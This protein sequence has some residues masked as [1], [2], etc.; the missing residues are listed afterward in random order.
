MSLMM[1]MMIYLQSTL[2]CYEETAAV[3]F[4][5]IRVLAAQADVFIA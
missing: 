4:Q 5:L 1:M 2:R 3:K